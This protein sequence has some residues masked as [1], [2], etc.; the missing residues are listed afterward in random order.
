[1]ERNSM[2]L[3]ILGGAGLLGAVALAMV[4]RGTTPAEVPEPEP[5]PETE[6]PAKPTVA[7]KPPGAREVP[8]AAFAVPE[9]GYT[10]T[11]SGLMWHDI[12]PGTGEQPQDGSLVVVEYAGFLEDGTLFD[13][14]YKRP[15]PFK[16]PLG[17]GAVIKGWDEG[18]ATMK[19]GGKRQLRIPGDL[20]YGPRGRPPTIPPNATLIFDVELVELMPPR[21]VPEAP[22][23][24]ADSDYTTT[25]SGLKFHDFA[26]GDGAVAAPGQLVE[27]EYSGWLED[28]TLFDSSFKRAEPIKF[29]LGAG[30][31]IKGWDE[32]LTGM[33]V[34]GKRQ[35]VIPSDIA[36]G[37]RG[38]PPVI[39]PNATLVF[40]VELVGVSN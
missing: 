8:S 31:V 33:Q 34:G 1:M 38:R 4:L 2:A 16:F 11:A 40:E 35:L 17:K 10:T 9:G 7:A 21:V 36:Y 37:D 28:G 19:V 25:E 27:V 3:L 12:T 20:A 5:V 15:N 24:V 29:P 14:S 18:V 13:A 6:A 32:G 30:R 26:R 39:P 22:Q 23:T